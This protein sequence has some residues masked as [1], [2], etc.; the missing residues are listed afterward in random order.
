MNLTRL[1]HTAALAGG[2]VL[3]VGGLAACGIEDTTPVAAHPD[4]QTSTDADVSARGPVTYL[5]DCVGEPVQKPSSY[6]VAC[7]DGNQSLV[8]LTWADWGADKATATGVVVANECLPNCAE[9]KDVRAEARVVASDIVNGEAS[10]T[11]G[12]LTITVTGDLPEGMD[13]EQEITLRTVDP[14]DPEMGPGA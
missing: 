12:T 13:P 5:L 14:V 2:G 3:L 1:R 9:G 11:Y 6:T 7:G 8:D 4:P 10:A